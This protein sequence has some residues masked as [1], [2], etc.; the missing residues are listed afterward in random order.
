MMRLMR[1][2]LPT[3]LA[4]LFSANVDA[5]LLLIVS[6]ESPVYQEFQQS[7]LETLN[8]AVAEE[9]DFRLASDVAGLDFSSYSAVVVA[10]FEAAKVVAAH[11]FPDKPLL[12]TMLPLSSYQW[13][14]ANSMLSPQH[15]LLYIDQ[16]VSRYLQ[17]LR[18]AMPD[19][20]TVGYLYG[21]TSAFYIEDIK[22][23]VDVTKYQ[24]VFGGL[25]GNNKLSNLLKNMFSDSDAMLLLPDPFFY[26][27]R[28]VQE[29]LLASFRYKRP[30]VAYSESFL[31]AGAML[32]LFS[33]PGQIGRQTAEIINCL[34]K[35]CYGAVMQ[36]SAPKY[37][38]VMVND[39]V[40]R[41]MGMSSKSAEELQ[42][43]LEFVGT[44]KSR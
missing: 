33:T 27:R 3:L 26:N 36:R 6:Q 1:L 20:T 11:N 30:L 25:M 13:L 17:L 37:F 2:I 34:G 22:K 40:A 28:V 31:K 15:K 42:K 16:P 14:D 44:L 43:E 12:Y 7:M 9:L 4:L 5:R 10:G 41:Q 23:I 18:A 8:S 24:I 32:A 19:I 21:E 39:V 35:R 29:I 38:S